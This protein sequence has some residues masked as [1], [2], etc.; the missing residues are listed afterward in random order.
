MVCEVTPKTR[1]FWTAITQPTSKI[2]SKVTVLCSHWIGLLDAYFRS[3]FYFLSSA[4]TVVKSCRRKND[5]QNSLGQSDKSFAASIA[6]LM[7]KIHPR[8]VKFYMSHH[9][10]HCLG[11]KSASL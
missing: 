10:T 3:F 4:A 2:E 1:N 9:Q 5:E 8:Q 11:G 7:R 6:N